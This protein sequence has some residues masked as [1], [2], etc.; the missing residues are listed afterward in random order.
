M[1]L[2][3]VKEI[4]H[5]DDLQDVN[6]RLQDGWVLIDTYTVVPDLGALNDSVLIY[7]LGRVK[8]S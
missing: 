1:N 5:I 7:S 4:I 6:R 3:D 2:T 8:E